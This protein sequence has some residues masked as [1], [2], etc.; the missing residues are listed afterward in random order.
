M[1]VLQDTA[2]SVYKCVQFTIY[3]PSKYEDS[4]VTV[5]D[6]ELSVENTQINHQFYEKPCSAKLVI[7]FRSVHSRN[8]KMSVL[9]EERLMRL[10]HDSRGMEWEK[11]RVVME[12]WAQELR[13]SGYPETVRHEVIQKNC[14]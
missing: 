5:K 4:Q 12:Q 11:S 6:V 3:I 1:K 8:M 10:R 9:V 14:L 13:R 2:N 7:S